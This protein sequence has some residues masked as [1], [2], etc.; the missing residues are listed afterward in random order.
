MILSLLLF[1]I[2]SFLVGFLLGGRE[3]GDR[4]V[5]SLGMAQRIE[6]H[7]LIEKPNL[8]RRLPC[9]SN[10]KTLISASLNN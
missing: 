2:G 9:K 3:A 5:M 8:K 4:S 10:P 1:I 7:K 6:W